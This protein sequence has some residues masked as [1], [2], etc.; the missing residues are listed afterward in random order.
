MILVSAAL[1]LPPSCGHVEGAYHVLK[2]NVHSSQWTLIKKLQGKNRKKNKVK[3][4]K[5]RQGKTF[6]NFEEFEEFEEFQNFQKF[7]KFDLT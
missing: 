3:I 2:H 5:K 4:G 7:Q 6:Q 1:Q